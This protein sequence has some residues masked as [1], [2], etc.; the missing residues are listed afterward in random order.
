MQRYELAV[1]RRAVGRVAQAVGTRRVIVT[2]D[3]GFADVALLTLL[4]QLGITFI[5]RVKAG[6]HV[7]CRGKWCKLGQV[8]LRGHERHRS[9]GALPYCESCPQRLWVSKSRARDA[10]GH[11]GMWHVVSNRPL[12]AVAA[13]NEYGRRFGCAEGFRD[14]KWWLG[15]TKARMAQIKAWSR[16]FALFAIALLVMTSLGSKL[17]LAQ[18]PRA[19]ALLRRVVSRRR[20]RCELGL[21]SAMVSLL[22]Q[23][24]TLYGELCPHVKLKLEAT[25]GNVS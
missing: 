17:L 12:A 10:K 21:V 8:R 6:T 2:A 23:D 19:K 20:G 16:M 18:G 1:I 13:A 24:K 9:F 22:Q 11:W 4:N 25:L 3:R 5:I 15:F 7:Y 14:A